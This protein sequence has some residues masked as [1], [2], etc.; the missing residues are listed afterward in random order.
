M[1]SDSEYKEMKDTVG[2]L[3][4]LNLVYADS[5]ADRP[6]NARFLTCYIVTVIKV[7]HRLP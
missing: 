6:F 3:A 2:L 4:N 1:V 7:G 5:L